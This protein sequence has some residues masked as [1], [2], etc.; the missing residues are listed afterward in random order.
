[1]DSKAG[2][3]TVNY[4]PTMDGLHPEVD[5]YIEIRVPGLNHLLQNDS[6]D[7]YQTETR[8]E[9]CP[10]HVSRPSAFTV[11]KRKTRFH[12][13]SR[14]NAEL[15]LLLVLL[16]LLFEKANGKNCTTLRCYDSVHGGQKSTSPNFSKSKRMLYA[17][18]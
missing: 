17:P 13:P 11:R 8:T 6:L 18:Y 14:K 9:M 2:E 12:H 3:D 1:M 10:S 16:S 15:E 5:L 4:V 7:I